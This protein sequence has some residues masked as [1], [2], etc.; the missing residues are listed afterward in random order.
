MFR[1]APDSFLHLFPNCISVKLHDLLFCFPARTSTFSR[2]G[3]D[4]SDSSLPDSLPPP[5]PPPLRTPF[6]LRPPPFAELPP[7]RGVCVGVDEGRFC[8][9]QGR[10]RQTERVSQGLPASRRSVPGV[11]A[12]AVAAPSSPNADTFTCRSPRAG[13][14]RTRT[15]LVIIAFNNKLTLGTCR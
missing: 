15:R 9:V 3:R 6:S 8:S 11:V 2:S 7:C 4:D 13:C 14:G 5:S 1:L 10:S 12:V